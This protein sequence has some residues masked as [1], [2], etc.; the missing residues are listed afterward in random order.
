MAIFSILDLSFICRF[1]MTNLIFL[2]FSAENQ[3]T[4]KTTS[5]VTTIHK[6]EMFSI[7]LQQRVNKYTFVT[8]QL[9]MMVMT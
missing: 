8:Q 2:S 3:N 5:I 4:S 6:L 9:G 1:P 7:A